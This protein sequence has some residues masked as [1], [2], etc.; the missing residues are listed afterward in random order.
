M[1]GNLRK[2]LALQAQAK[3]GLS[4]GLFACGLVALVCGILT[5]GF[6]LLIAFI[7]LAERYG[8]LIAAAIFAGIFLLVTIVA[9][10]CSLQSRRR[11][12]ERA[13]VALAARKQAVWLDPKL[14]AGAVQTGR[15]VGWRRFVPLLAL[16][17]LAATVGME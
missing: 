5:A 11:T 8:P 13:E 14:V 10:V 9:I 3:T 16:G 17:V 6:I 4:S 2:Y 1:M 15:V 7:W 12:V